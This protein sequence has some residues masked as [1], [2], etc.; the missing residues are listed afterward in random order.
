MG[1]SASWFRMIII[2]VLRSCGPLFAWEF[3]CAVIV[4]GS[5][6]SLSRCGACVYP[7]RPTAL[8]NTPRLAPKF[9]ASPNTSSQSA[10]YDSSPICC[11]IYS[12][13]AF[14]FLYLLDKY[15][16][17]REPLLK[18]A[19]RALF[20][21]HFISPAEALWY[22]IAGGGGG[23]QIHSKITFAAYLLNWRRFGG[24]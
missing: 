22:V 19:M 12:S 16:R 15:A 24:G 13:L 5:L 10:D 20:L 17:E 8:Q 1:G 9:G 14:L 6:S 11:S 7:S 23:S 18:H 21:R 3:A 2:I 4:C